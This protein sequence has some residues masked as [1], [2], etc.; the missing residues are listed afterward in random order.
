MQYHILIHTGEKPF[1][2]YLCDKKFIRKDKCD[3]HIRTVE[4]NPNNVVL[5]KAH[6]GV[7]TMISLSE[8]ETIPPKNSVSLGDIKAWG[9]ASNRRGWIGSSEHM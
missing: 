9:I 4:Y 8:D 6:K 5:I 2:Y 7:T 3:A 1:K